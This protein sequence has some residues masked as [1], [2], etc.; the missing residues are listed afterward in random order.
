MQGRHVSSA[1]SAEARSSA[2][3][4]ETV[5][6][7]HHLPR[8]AIR[9]LMATSCAGPTT[10]RAELKREGGSCPCRGLMRL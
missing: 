4:G 10:T 1:L 2:L 8:L 3:Q 7:V 9:S 6:W 5:N